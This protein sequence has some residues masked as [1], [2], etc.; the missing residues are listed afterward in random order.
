[1]HDSRE[2]YVQQVLLAIVSKRLVV[3][4]ENLRMDSRFIE[5]LGADSLDLVDIVG[6]LEERLALRIDEQEIIHMSTLGD[7]VRYLADRIERADSKARDR[8]P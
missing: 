6:N 3:K 8:A 4:H 1:M 5:D 2:H 7:A